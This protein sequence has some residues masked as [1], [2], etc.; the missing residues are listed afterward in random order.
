MHQLIECCKIV[1]GLKPQH[2]GAVTGDYVSMKG[3][4]HLTA[5][6]SVDN[7]PNATGND[8]HLYKATAVDATGEVVDQTVN[9]WYMSNDVSTDDTLT[10]QTAGATFT[11]TAAQ[12]PQ[13]IVLE[14][15]AEDFPGYDCFAVKADAGNAANF[16]SVVYIL[17]EPRY[18]GDMPSAIVD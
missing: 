11:T 8:F 9:N 15:N 17:S 1:T 16:M 5:I 18:A 2:T 10:K 4:Q 6:I 13:V 3:Y 14:I 7:T 12:K